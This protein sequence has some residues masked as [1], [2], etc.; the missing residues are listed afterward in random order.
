M[1]VIAIA[2]TIGLTGCTGS[3]PWQRPTAN[4]QTTAPAAE[5][6]TAASESAGFASVID[7]DTI[8]TSAGTIR[9]IG[10]DTPERGECGHDE[11]S[12]AIERLLAPG[13][14][15]TLDLP[16]GQNDH[17]RHGRLLRYVITESGVDLGLM[18]LEAGNAIARY[19]ATDGYPAH[20]NQDIY[21]EAQRASSGPAGNVITTACQ[22]Q[23][24]PPSPPDGRWWE[25]YSSCAKL[26]R[27]TAGHPTGPF[28]RDDPAQAEVYDW[29]ANRTGNNGDGDQDGLACEG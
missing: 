25:R 29:F 1:A 10:I 19:D 11:A 15:V 4:G 3:A 8:E 6:T 23:A 28:D 22:N 24:P 13:D 26:K 7:G 18:Q 12:A 14:P 9:I 2:W 20:P 21:H 17:D 16:P 5:S 27:N